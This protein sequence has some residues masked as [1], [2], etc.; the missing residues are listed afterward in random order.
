MPLVKRA[1]IVESI[2]LGIEAKTGV[3]E[4]LTSLPETLLNACSTSGVC[5]W[6]PPNL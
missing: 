3:K 4:I 6:I 1:V 5:W 2:P